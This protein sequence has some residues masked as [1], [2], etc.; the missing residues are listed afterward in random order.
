MQRHRTILLLL[1]LVPAV[2]LLATPWLPFVNSARLWAGLPSMFVW[3]SAWVL[4]IVP[5]LA[6]VE[7]GRQRHR[8]TAPERSEVGA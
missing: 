3:T 6:A 1:P 4:A 7:W 5:A 2:A 8:D